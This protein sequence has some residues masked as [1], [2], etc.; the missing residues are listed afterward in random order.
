MNIEK[1][2]EEIYNYVQA[3]DFQTLF[4][5]DVLPYIELHSFQK[6]ETS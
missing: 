5:F 3:Y 4:S 1:N 2:R 6:K